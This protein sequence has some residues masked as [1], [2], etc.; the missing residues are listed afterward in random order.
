MKWEAASIFGGGHK[1]LV[2]EH[3]KGFNV[4]GRCRLVLQA[5]TGRYRRRS[6][7]RATKARK[8]TYRG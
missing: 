8:G 3:A 4:G 6:A 1:A 5:Q 7:V 2:E